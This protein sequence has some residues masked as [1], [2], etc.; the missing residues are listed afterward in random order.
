MADLAHFIVTIKSSSANYKN[1]KVIMAGGS[2]SATM[3]AWFRQKYPHLADGVW[4]SSAP[5]FAKTDFSE[6]KEVMTRSVE[7]MGGEVC[8]EQIRG[9]FELMEDA[10]RANN[11]LKVEKAFNLCSPLDHSK[12]IAHFFYEVSDIVAGLVQGKM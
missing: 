6:Y 9:A 2:Y 5:L 3:V 11:T 1:S 7:L 4:A 12:D 10:V 8:R